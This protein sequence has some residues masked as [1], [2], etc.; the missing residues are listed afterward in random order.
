MSTAEIAREIRSKLPG[1]ED[2]V[3]DYLSGYLVDDASADEDSMQ[4]T[5]DML[6]SFAEKKP[7]ALEELLKSLGTMLADRLAVQMSESSIAGPRRLERAMEMGKAGAMSNTLA[8]AEG[9]DI[10]SINKAKWA[11]LRHLSETGHLRCLL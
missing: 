10:E 11:D 9:V 7:A 5:R 6:E 4:V 1:T 3:V 2:L 8:F